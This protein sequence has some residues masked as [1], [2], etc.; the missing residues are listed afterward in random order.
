[1]SPEGEATDVFIRAVDGG[2]PFEVVPS[3]THGY[4][5]AAL[6][7]GEHEFTF[8]VKP[9]D[10]QTGRP[11]VLTFEV[12]YTDAEGQSQR[13][14]GQVAIEVEA[15]REYYVALGA[16]HT[17]RDEALSWLEKA[18]AR[19]RRAQREN[20]SRVPSSLE[21]DPLRAAMSD[22]AFDWLRDAA[23]LGARLL[24]QPRGRDGGR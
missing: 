8:M 9:V 10:A 11:H 4:R 19:G 24:S 23:T 2:T 6:G 1:M 17:L 15:R 21:V 16:I 18:E 22:G 5:L 14:F 20:P 13:H 12:T 3:A 7:A